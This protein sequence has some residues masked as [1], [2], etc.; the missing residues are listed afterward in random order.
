MHANTFYQHVYF[1]SLQVQNAR[2]NLERFAFEMCWGKV[3]KLYPKVSFEEFKIKYFADKFS[4]SIH[5][6]GL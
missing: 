2:L 3:N 1:D 6:V 4:S 5:D